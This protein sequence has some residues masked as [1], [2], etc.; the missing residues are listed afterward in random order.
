M[1]YEGEVHDIADQMPGGVNAYTYFQNVVWRKNGVW[2]S[3]SLN[4]LNTFTYGGLWFPGGSN[5]GIY[6]T[7]FSS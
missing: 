7:R 2:Y 3:G 4:A 6:D 5:I 1:E